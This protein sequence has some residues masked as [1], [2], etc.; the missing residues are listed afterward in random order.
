M[1]KFSKI[2]LTILICYF[3]EE[4][5]DVLIHDFSLYKAPLPYPPF[6]WVIRLSNV[7]NYM[8]S[9]LQLILVLSCG[10]KRDW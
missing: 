5:L 8:L 3:C 6:P 2:L 7:I 4:F 1:N 9:A 10:F